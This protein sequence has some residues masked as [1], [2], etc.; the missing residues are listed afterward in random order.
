MD[1]PIETALA[2]LQ[3]DQ[4]ANKEMIARLAATTDRIGEVAA[5]VAKILAV[6]DERITSAEHQTESLNQMIEKRRD[7]SDRSFRE[8]Y[9]RIDSIERN[10]KRDLDEVKDEII[11]A[12]NDHIKKQGDDS[13][14]L[15]RRVRVLENWRWMLIGGGIILGFIVGRLPTVTELMKFMGS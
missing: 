13:D 6:H 1:K 5:Y 2:L 4:S 14:S 8:V 11:K 7:E 12:F 9:T 15:A 3:H 10:V